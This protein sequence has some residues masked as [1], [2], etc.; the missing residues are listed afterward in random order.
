MTPWGNV[1]Y[2]R[3]L[4][5]R[6]PDGH[7]PR[8]PRWTLAYTEPVTMLTSEYLGIQVESWESV[9]VQAFLERIRASHNIPHPGAPEAW[10]LLACT[11]D[12]G[13]L[14]IIHL[15]YWRNP[16]HH[17]T[18]YSSAPLGRWYDGLDAATIAFGAWREV[19]Q[20][21]LDHAETIYSDP[22]GSFGL[23]ACPGT[24]VESM[25][26]NGYFGAARDRLPV[27]A[28]DPLQVAQT[29]RPPNTFRE[30]RGRRLRA[31][32]HH[33]MAVIRSGQFWAA[34]GT[35][36]RTDYE[37]SLQ[38]K[39]SEGMQYLSR[40]KEAT[41]TLALRELTSLNRDTLTPR[42]ETSTYAHFQSLADVEAWAEDHPTHH[43]IYEHAIDKNREYGSDR[44]VTTWHEVFIMPSSARFEYVNCDPMTGLLPS[45]RT[46]LAVE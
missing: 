21:P 41:G 6:K 30:T 46:V 44:E 8:A 17:E 20:V 7:Q 28:I 25:T 10:E 5:A 14:N 33:N 15:A 12:A 11:D 42:R 13:L 36:Q 2:P 4:P 38:P 29:T 18:W 34:A 1:A 37:E 39:L 43:A 24:E 40:H 3:Q 45:A 16:L 31:E 26:V 23:A 35:E 22:R 19:I 32:T 9:G 27:S